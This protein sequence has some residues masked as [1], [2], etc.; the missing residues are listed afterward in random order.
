VGNVVEMNAPA[1]RGAASRTA[2]VL[3]GGGF[4]G[5][6]YQIGALR[7]LDLLSSTARSTSSTSTSAP[8]PA[9]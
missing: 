3:G 9:R 8:A 5:G 4:T 7:A 1:R 6:V 2:L